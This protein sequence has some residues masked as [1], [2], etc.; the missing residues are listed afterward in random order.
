MKEK[1][2]C[3]LTLMVQKVFEFESDGGDPD[4]DDSLEL[5]RDKIILELRNAGF[6]VSVLSEEIM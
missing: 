6:E 3:S 1:F 5:E 2:E 4:F